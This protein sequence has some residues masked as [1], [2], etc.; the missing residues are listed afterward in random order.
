[1]K[2]KLIKVMIC[3]ITLNM[4]MLHTVSFAS[5]NDGIVSRHTI[6]SSDLAEQVKFKWTDLNMDPVDLKNHWA[7]RVFQWA[8]LNNMIDGYS[9]GSYQPNRPMSEVEFL[10]TFYRAFGAALFVSTGEDWTNGPY[11]LAS[12]WKHPVQGTDDKSLRV[13][14]ITRIQ[15]AEIIASAQGVNYQGDEAIKF[16]LGN[17]LASGKTLPT[18]EGFSGSDVLTRAEAVQWIRTLKLKGVGKILQRPTPPS[19]P[20]VLPPLNSGVMDDIQDFVTVPLLKEDLNLIDKQGN[21]VIK[22][23]TPK[24][25]FD[26]K[27]GVSKEKNVVKMEMYGQLSVHFDKNGGMDAWSIDDS[28]LI[29]SNFQTNQRIVLNEN[30]LFDVLQTYGTEGYGGNGIAEYY[31]EKV[32]D[33]LIPRPSHSQ[34]VDPNNTYVISFTFDQITHRVRFIFV[35]T[36][37]FASNPL[38]AN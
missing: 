20:N 17:G 16:L 5:S 7:E 26:S 2:T 30:T 11:R 21:T 27:Y 10:K 9:D 22:F 12:M 28:S 35:S 4:L 31:Y 37:L 23:G 32:G 1:L 8:I 14:P 29:Q 15:A 38:R 13:K 34:I 19:D 3:G 6:D 33:D 25:Y 36:H 18:L 24:E